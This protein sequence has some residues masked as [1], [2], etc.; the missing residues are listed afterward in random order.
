MFF[1]VQGDLEPDMQVE[2]IVNGSAENLADATGFTL[3]WEKPDGGT[4]EVPLD[5]VNAATGVFKRTWVV[6][7]TDAVGVH[8]GQLT[9][10]RGN[11][12]VATFPSDGS[13][14]RWVVSPRIGGI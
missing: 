11:G 5:V 13:R 14:L 12:E 10:T 7:D 8:T 6:G 9:C 2:A 3:L 4:S 1:I